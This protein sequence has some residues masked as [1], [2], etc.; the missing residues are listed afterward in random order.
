MEAKLVAAEL[1]PL[2]VEVVHLRQAGVARSTIE[3]QVARE[4]R[5]GRGALRRILGQV[6]EH[7]REIRYRM[8]LPL[9]LSVEALRLDC[10]ETAPRRPT[11]N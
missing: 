7:L 11:A 6:D 1:V 3:D 10:V 5:I 4:R 8:S 2:V 9:A